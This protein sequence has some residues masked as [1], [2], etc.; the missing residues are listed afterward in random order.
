M[1]KLTPLTVC[2]SKHFEQAFFTVTMENTNECESYVTKD[3]LW[4]QI[5][6]LC[7][8]QLGDMDVQHTLPTEYLK[9]FL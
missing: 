9:R 5:K 3:P 2:T 6:I 7:P 1:S 4:N 8:R